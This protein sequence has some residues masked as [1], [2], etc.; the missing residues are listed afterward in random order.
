MP[1]SLWKGNISF[2]LVN[3]PIILYPAEDKSAHISFREIDKRT[4]SRIKH[5]RI[6]ADTGKVVPWEDVVKGYEYDKDQ[7]YIVG[8]GELEKVAGENARTI[9]IENFVDK[10]SLNFLNVDR[11]YYL[12]PDKKGDKGYV[13]LREALKATNKVGIAKIII[14]TKEYLAA[15]ATY[16]NALV[17]YLLRYKDEVRDLE[18]FNIPSENLSQYKVK[19]AEIDVA[20][21]L[22]NSMTTKWKPE[23]YKDEYKEAVQEWLNNK[24]HKKTPIMMRSRSHAEKATNVVDFVS[25]L[26]KSMSTKKTAKND[27]KYKTKAKKTSAKSKVQKRRVAR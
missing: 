11:V 2:G 7:V 21:Q 20:K 14:S 27:P 25:L 8:E 22:I 13:I 5:Q 9:A 3:I 24:I 17:V 12:E 19:K 10:K 26:K 1:H 16:E 15:I 6:N 4:N 18:N 23:K